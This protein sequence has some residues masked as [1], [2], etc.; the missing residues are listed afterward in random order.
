MSFEMIDGDQGLAQTKRVR[1][2]ERDTDQQRTGKSGAGGDGYR[3]EIFSRHMSGAQGL[4]HN[5]DNV[6]KM[7]TASQLGHHAAVERVHL[8]LRRDDVRQN[9][10]ATAHHRG[11]RL[12]ARAF[13]AQNQSTAHMPILARQTGIASRAA[14]DVPQKGR[15]FAISCIVRGRFVSHRIRPRGH[16]KLR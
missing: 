10:A 7:L 8:H 15:I 2:R 9:C 14:K 12:V 1:L 4:A 13:N 3:I 5:G 16:L 11:R 6:P